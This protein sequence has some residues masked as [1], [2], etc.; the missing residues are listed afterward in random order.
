[1]APEHNDAAPS[2]VGNSRVPGAW[3]TGPSCTVLRGSVPSPVSRTRSRPSADW[4]SE[5]LSN[6]MERHD[7][8]RHQEAGAAAAGRGILEG[9]PQR[10]RRGLLAAGEDHDAAARAGRP[11]RHE[12]VRPRSAD[13]VP[14]HEVHHRRL[15]RLRRDGGAPVVLHRH[16]PGRVHG[17]PGD[18][19]EGHHL[20]RL[21]L[22]VLGREARR[23][24]SRSTTCS[25][26]SSRSARRR[27]SPASRRRRRSDPR[28]GTEPRQS[29]EPRPLPSVRSGGA[30]AAQR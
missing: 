29:I 5:P 14:G 15:D 1:M 24:T 16:A 21:D 22:P 19:Q 17:R 28:R 25:A 27:F 8:H 3:T 30:G 13:R 12:G 2:P 7:G 26:C 6:E 10:L 18:E 4:V 23:I 9:Q 20:G 11:R